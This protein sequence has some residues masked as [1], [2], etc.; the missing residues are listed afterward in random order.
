MKQLFSLVPR[1]F[2]ASEAEV[3]KL[4]S[5][6]PYPISDF[7]LQNDYIKHIA[8]AN[9]NCASQETFAK[10]FFGWLDGLKTVKFLN[11]SCRQT[12]SKQSPEIAAN[13]LL[14]K[15]GYKSKVSTRELLE[16]YRGMENG[17]E[18]KIKN[19]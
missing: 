12:Y 6:L 13:I 1:L 8:Q 4:C 2:N 3:E 11:D 7:L 9:A 10:R 15:L 14:Q 19:G 17:E 18:S 5:P 16:T